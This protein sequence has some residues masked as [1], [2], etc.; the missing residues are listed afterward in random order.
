VLKFKEYRAILQ[1]YEREML[2]SGFSFEKKLK[3][4]TE[5]LDAALET[6]S[7]TTKKLL[8]GLR[9]IKDTQDS[10]SNTLNVLAQNHDTLKHIDKGL[11]ETESEL[12]IASRLITRA[13]KRIATDKIIAGT[14]AL[15]TI[16]LIGIGL[17]GGGVIPIPH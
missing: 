17:I 10:G 4:N 1:K 8:D 6:E 11:D 2:L 5:Y 16:G 7:K 14:A 3:T 12:Y 15:A 9:I 13:A